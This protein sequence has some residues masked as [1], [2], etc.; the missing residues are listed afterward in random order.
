[1]W[2][3]SG[4]RVIKISHTAPYSIAQLYLFQQAADELMRESEGNKTHGNGSW[5]TSGPPC[6]LQR[7]WIPAELVPACFIAPDCQGSAQVVPEVRK[8]RT[9]AY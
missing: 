9:C 3:F 4:A 5:E 6:R 8:R 1:M 2:A 7:Y